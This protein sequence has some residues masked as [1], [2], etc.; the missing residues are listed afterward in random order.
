MTSQT[1]SHQVREAAARWAERLEHDLT[2]AEREG[3]HRW[4]MADE[5]HQRE[6]RAHTA[7]VNMSRDLPEATREEL[8]A[9]T[10]GASPLQRSGKRRV[11]T[12][13]LA[14]S[15]LLALGLTG[16]FVARDSAA[17][18]HYITLAGTTRNVAL[19]DGSIAHLNTRTDLRWIR[20]AN[21]RHLE[22]LAGEALFEVRHDPAKPFTVMLDGSEIRVLGTRFN[23]RRRQNAQIVVTVLEG[24]VAIDSRASGSARSA[25]T[26]RLEANEQIVYSPAGLVR[27]VHPAAAANAA[28]WREGVLEFEDEPLSNIVEDLGRYTDRRIVV[29]DAR[30]AQ[31]RLGGQLNV[32]DKIENS[33]ALLEKLA[34]VAA[35]QSGDSFVLDYRAE[36]FKEST[37]AHT[38]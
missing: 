36:P 27:D 10:S 5:S 20:R 16:W 19:P 31:L 21:E 13:G 32:H 15:A 11:W 29:R 6:F 23:V 9:L 28:R 7:I 24:T 2:H 18:T 12:L 33:L 35:H 22:L 4:L 38:D 30:V 3:F 25:W 8:S 1:A 26:R 14:A 34:P 17:S 37:D